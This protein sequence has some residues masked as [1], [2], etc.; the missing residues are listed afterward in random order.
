M[1]ATTEAPTRPL[2]TKV[3]DA[4]GFGNAA[5]VKAAEFMAAQEQRQ[6]EAEALIP[7]ATAALISGERIGDTEEQKTKT[8]AILKDHA[9]T[10]KLLCRVAMHK[11]AAENSL[12]VPVDP[13]GQT[14]TAGS[15]GRAYDSL[16]DPRTGLRTTMIKQ[17]DQSLFSGL[18]LPTPTG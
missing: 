11:N 1:S 5:L 6:K 9:Q 16:T 14:K 2:P 4:V 3:I 10:L 18:G 12:G 15:N 7:E 13:T 8:A 17:S